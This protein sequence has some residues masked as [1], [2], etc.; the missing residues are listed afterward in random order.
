MKSLY[1]SISLLLFGLFSCNSIQS[2]PPG[3]R[4]QLSISSDNPV[5]D[6]LYLGFY[7]N[8]STFLADTAQH[9]GK[10][11]YLFEDDSVTLE[12]GFYF[13]VN[14][15]KQ[16]LF[17]FVIGDDQSFDITLTGTGREQEIDVSGD[18]ENA[19]FFQI[20]RNNKANYL[21][22]LPLIKIAEDSLAL[23]DDR[24]SAREELNQIQAEATE[25]RDAFIAE[26]SQSIA[27]IYLATLKEVP[28]PKQ[29]PNGKED[30]L[31]R[32]LYYKYHYFDYTPLS[33]PIV[34]RLPDKDFFKDKIKFYLSEVVEPF[35]DSLIVAI[36][37]L[38]S[39]TNGNQSTIQ[40]IVWIATVEYQRPKIMGLDKVF[41]HLYDTY[42][43][44]GLMDD[45]ANA[46]LKGNIKKEAD[47]MR[48]SL[49]GNTGPNL[50]MQNQNLQSRSLYDLQANYKLLYF[51]DPDCHACSKETPRVKE[52]VSKTEY[53]VEVY[54]VCADTSLVKLQEYIQKHDL[55]DKWT[56]VSG[57]RSYVGPYHKLYDARSTPTIILLDRSHAII[58][59][60]IGAE[61]LQGFLE[62]YEKNTPPN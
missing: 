5:E 40:Q 50:T 57:P 48:L 39:E 25:A 43:A 62:N 2:S 38:V 32:Y 13:F 9:A 24:A 51:F 34:L 30:S 36:D 47:N 21:A 14:E 4:I 20:S 53:N 8:G 3:Y 28:T 26:N 58:A 52:F 11:I 54:A 46:S 27:A 22:A 15:A 44:T 31:S 19:L 49:I 37:H 17:D 60:K 61:T 41:V 33:N 45:L 55:R 29:L 7:Y 10:G 23:E 12:R 56:V 16:P 18:E 35:A 59:K 6:I 1:L 42:Y